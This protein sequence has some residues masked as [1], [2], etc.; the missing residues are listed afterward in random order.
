MKWTH[1]LGLSFLLMGALAGLSVYRKNLT[2]YISFKDAVRSTG[3]VQ[4][5]GTLEKSYTHYD[6]RELSFRIKDEHGTTMDVL[7]ADVKPGNFD[8]ARDI[9]AIGRF[10]SGHF[11]AQKLLVK[12]PSKYQ[13][14][15]RK[16]GAPAPQGGV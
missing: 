8:Q 3:V 4:V 16:Q 2:P 15:Q 5:H 6:G 9:V 1:A 10:Q 11:H 7:Y 12:C 13:E 14:M